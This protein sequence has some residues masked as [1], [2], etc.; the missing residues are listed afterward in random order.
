ML[1]SLI[2]L[3]VMFEQTLC[4]DQFPPVLSEMDSLDRLR[5]RRWRLVGGIETVEA[6]APPATPITLGT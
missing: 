2:K 5:E 1:Y 3:I 6:L 4:W